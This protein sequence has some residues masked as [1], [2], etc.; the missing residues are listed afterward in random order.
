MVHERA[1]GKVRSVAQ[2]SREKY[3]IRKQLHAA[4]Q[5]LTGAVGDEFDKSGVTLRASESESMIRTWGYE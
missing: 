4:V 1:F 2:G 5:S 3:C